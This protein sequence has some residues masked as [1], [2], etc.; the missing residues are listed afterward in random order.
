M[1]DVTKAVFDAFPDETEFM[2]MPK[3]DWDRLLR[4]VKV[5]GLPRPLQDLRVLTVELVP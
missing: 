5:I 4:Y 1:N 3:D 2:V